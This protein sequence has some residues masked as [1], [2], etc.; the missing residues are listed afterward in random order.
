MQRV[1]RKF[2]G[3]WAGN[4][5]NHIQVFFGK[6]SR[7]SSMAECHFPKVDVAG[8]N[9]VSCSFLLWRIKARHPIDRGQGK[10]QYVQ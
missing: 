9:P 6:L 5:Y 2:A 3:L 8:S 4:F 1:G 10:T 7:S